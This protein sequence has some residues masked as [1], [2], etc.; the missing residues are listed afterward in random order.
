MTDWRLLFGK[1]APPVFSY[2]YEFRQMMPE[3]AEIAVATLGVREIETDELMEARDQRLQAATALAEAGAECIVAG[4]G[5]VSTAAGVEDEEEFIRKA[6]AELS[7]PFT[8]SL[9]AQKDAFRALD[10]TSILVV[11]PFS[12]RRDAELKEYLEHYG[13]EVAAVGGMNVDRVS[14]IRKTTPGASY[15]CAR[16]LA[17]QTGQ[18]F[19][20][21]YIAC[22]AWES[23]AYIDA[24]EEDT[25][26]S[27][28]TSTQA[29]LWSGMKMAG[30]H[31]QINDYGELF[32]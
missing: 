15:R 5:P 6:R 9:E 14:D 27:V 16:E 21:I 11:T 26:R 2:G 13:F 19:D 22:A 31:P 32:S 1:I 18:P 28:V 3:G 7:I 4:G 29:Q 17:H 30:V 10:A 12:E 25:A 23:V 8:T 24:L 20:L